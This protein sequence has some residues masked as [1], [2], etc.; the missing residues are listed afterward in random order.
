MTT[1]EKKHYDSLITFLKYTLGITGSCLTIIIAVGIY[2]TYKSSTDFKQD[3]KDNLQSTKEEIKNSLLESKDDISKL[4]AFSTKTMSDVKE[5]AEK[6]IL[7][8]RDEAVYEALKASK[9]KVEQAFKEKN[10]Q[11]VIDEA[12][13]TEIESRVNAIVTNNLQEMPNFILA[14]D[15]IRAGVRKSFIYVDSIAKNSNDSFYKSMA[16][17]II[18]E[19]TRDYENSIPEI[20]SF[21]EIVI[22][23]LITFKNVPYE[24]IDIKAIEKN[25]DSTEV[26]CRKYF[27]ETKKD[28]E[29]NENLNIVAFD[30]KV[31]R[32][33]TKVPIKM[34]DFEAS[35]KL[36]YKENI[37]NPK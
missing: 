10:I 18:E 17:K 11:K 35:N 16:K 15:K 37:P 13:K 3:L 33:L 27:I 4:Y 14:V 20:Q 28:I 5:Q 29:Q 32:F 6:T 25:I 26:S 22:Y 34:F 1:D 36:Q 8:V 9:E 30:F 2:F 24:L 21:K 19:K 23:Q 12:V 7:N 31:L